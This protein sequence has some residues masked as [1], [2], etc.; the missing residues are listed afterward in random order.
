MAELKKYLDQ[1]GLESLVTKIKSEDDAHLAESK[2]YAESLGKNYDAAGAATTAETNAK[3]YTDQVAATLETKGEA[4]KVQTNLDTEVQARQNADAGLQGQIDGVKAT[5]DKAAED[6]AAINNAETGILAQAKEDAKSKADAVQAKVDELD[7]KVGEIPVGEDGQPLASTVVELINK[8]T[9]GIVTNAALGQLQSDLDQA[10]ADIEAIEKDYL[11][12]ADKE[13]VLGKVTEEAGLRKDADDALEARIKTIE[14]DYLTSA[15]KTTLEQSI[16]ANAGA[17]ERL[18]NGVSAEEVDG[19]N[20][21]IQYVKDH[22]TE[23]TGIKKDISDNTAA[24][25]AEVTRAKA[26]EDEIVAAVATKAEAQAL[27]DAVSALEQVDA[28]FDERLQVVETALGD[29]EGSVSDQIADAKQEVLE[30]AAA[31]A[32]S[33]ANTAEQNAKGHADSLNT[34]MNA[35]V[36]A[37]EAIDHEHA[38]K[39][40]L[41]KFAEGDKAKLDDAVA[42][43]HEHANKAELDKI[44][45]G[46]VAKWNAAEQNAKDYADGLNTAMTAKVDAIDE[47]VKTAESTL[48][49]KADADDVE[50]IDERLVTAEANIAANTSAIGAFSAIPTSDIEALFA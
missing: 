21:L 9:E 44:V 1:V 8:K 43:A 47:R 32:E 14:D 11:K 42:K 4:A 37:L 35:R 7:E 6:I 16:A 33:K 24:I 36:E 39:A 31:D 34:A 3:A 20:D 45:E 48:S 29:G 46:D 22:G 28:G 41:D 26:K 17:I 40:E 27:T 15:D 12:A 10:E 49:T 19:V 50:A 25:E 5:A 18:T 13:E 2:S 23:V 30:T 38:N